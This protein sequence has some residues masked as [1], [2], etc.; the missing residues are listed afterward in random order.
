MGSPGT[1][2]APSPPRQIPAGGRV[3]NSRL[4]AGA[5]GGHGSETRVRP[6]YR[7]AK[8]TRRGGMGGRESERFIVP[9]TRGNRPE[10]P[11][12]GKG[13]S[14]HETAGGND[15]GDTGP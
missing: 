6:W 14:C 8:A 2:E 12:R 10:G 11:R 4:V 3:T 7:Q 5:P 15:A 9:M 13:T 1:W